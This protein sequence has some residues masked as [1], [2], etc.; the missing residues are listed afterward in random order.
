MD[1]DAAS[2]RARAVLVVLRGLMRPPPEVTSEAGV[3]VYDRVQQAWGAS[4]RTVLRAL[5]ELEAC[6]AIR[7]EGRTRGLRVVVLAPDR[8]ASSQERDAIGRRTGPSAWRSLRAQLGGVRRALAE[9]QQQRDDAR[10]RLHVLEAEQH[11]TAWRY[12]ASPEIVALRRDLLHAADCG[13]PDC[14]RCAEAL[15]QLEADGPRYAD[16]DE[17]IARLDRGEVVEQASV[18]LVEA[19]RGGRV[20]DRQ[21]VQ[22][23][24]GAILAVRRDDLDVAR[25]MVAAL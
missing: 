19:L 16:V 22:Q 21:R 20:G 10:A 1:V 2:Q 14:E 15:F 8:G 11:R 5:D 6:R 25:H 18:A 13:D 7:R 3:S 24:M 9:V 17:L 12:A 23:A 4:R